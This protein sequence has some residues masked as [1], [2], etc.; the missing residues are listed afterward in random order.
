MAYDFHHDVGAA[1]AR[2]S[3]DLRDGVV[4]EV[5]GN[6]TDAFRFL[7]ALGHGVDDVDF[8]DESEGGG[9]GTNPNRSAADA[10]DGEFFAVA[11]GEVLEVARGGEVACGEDVGHE[12]EHFFGDVVRGEDEGGVG[13]GA[14]DVFG[15][16]AVDGVGWGGVAE[17][18]AL[19]GEC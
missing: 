14:A 18:F 8:V 2:G 17:E 11:V 13:E 16:A 15:L 19:V 6:G 12:D 7:E 5:D 10:D 1:A 3:F 4:V 9:D